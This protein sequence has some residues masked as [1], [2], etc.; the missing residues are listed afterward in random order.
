MTDACIRPEDFASLE[1]LSQ[2]NPMRAHLERCARCRS[3][4]LDY[5]SFVSASATPSELLPDA[6]RDCLDR[7][8]REQA[9]R[10]VPR[11]ARA[12]LL[13]RLKSQTGRWMVLVPATCAVLVGAYLAIDAQRRPDEPQLR[14]IDG[15]SAPSLGDASFDGSGNLALAWTA[16][17][18]ATGYQ[19][20]L[21]TTDLKPI[22]RGSILA[23]TAATLPLDALPL[24][25]LG[26][27]R[28]LLW[29]VAAYEGA[30]E[31]SLSGVGTI[32][33]P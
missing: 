5:Q 10:A 32:Q 33:V 16:A 20:R 7:L 1:R 25:S 18:G 22:Y 8:I 30:R 28:R 26:P 15:A 4:Y 31:A 24:A 29:R 17:T 21:Y 12:S 13:E 19:V 2:E 27:D 3:R 11:R 23:E 14:S 6:S 9:R